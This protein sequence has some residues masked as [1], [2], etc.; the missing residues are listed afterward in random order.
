MKIPLSERLLISLI[1]L[2]NLINSK[3][4]HRLFTPKNPEF[5][6][7]V[8][9]ITPKSKKK[10]KLTIVRNLKQRRI[11]QSTSE[12]VP[13]KIAVDFK[14]FEDIKTEFKN[15]KFHLKKINKN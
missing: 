11:T 12:A 4:Q 9:R 6:K 10:Y 1:T 5:E 15:G 7:K 13:L 14:H 8:E 2:I 3:P